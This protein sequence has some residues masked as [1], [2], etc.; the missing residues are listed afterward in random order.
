MKSKLIVALTLFVILC[1]VN[2]AIWKKEQHL[3]HG[4]EVVLELAPVD[5]RSIMQGDYMALQFEVGRKVRRALLSVEGEQ[6]HEQSF[7][8][9]MAQDGYVI[10][11]KDDSGVY[12]FVELYDG[13]PLN[14][15]HK[16]LQFRARNQRVKF[17]TNAF[18][19][20]EGQEP[21]F[22]DARYGLFKLNDKGE[23][24]LTSLLDEN[25]GVIQAQ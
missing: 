25:L 5:P 19:F 3:T 9:L 16:K 18:F 4:E 17:A 13:K 23:V 12:R 22:R 20:A 11:K 14:D 8:R 7:N 15:D 1:L 24:L 10:V 21:T 2:H 6:A